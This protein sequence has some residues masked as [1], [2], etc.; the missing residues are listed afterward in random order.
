VFLS[1]HISVN[2]VLSVLLG[3]CFGIFWLG[4]WW[5]CGIPVLSVL[6]A[7]LT[8]GFVVA[9]TVTYGWLGTLHL[10]TCKVLVHVVCFDVSDLH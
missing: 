3:L 5:C 4:L 6:L 10:F 2:I 8:L 1:I 7:T 9:G